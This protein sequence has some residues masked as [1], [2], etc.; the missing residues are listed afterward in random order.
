MTLARLLRPAMNAVMLVYL[1]TH[2]VAVPPGTEAG[3]LA[4]SAWSGSLAW[5]GAWLGT[6]LAPIAQL[7]LPRS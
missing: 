1:V 5:L 7:L 6:R 2:G 4:R 3:D